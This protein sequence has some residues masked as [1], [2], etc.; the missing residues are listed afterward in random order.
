[1]AKC[2]SCGSIIISGGIKDN[3]LRFCN[4]QCYQNGHVLLLSR[5]VPKNIVDEQAR[6]IHGG[7]CPKC[8]GR[9]PI[10]VHTSYRIISVFV[11]SSWQSIPHI[12]CRAC[13]RK[14]QI[15]DAIFCL[16]LG[17]WGIPWGFFMTPVQIF[18]NIAGIISGPNE[19]KPSDQLD[20]LVR[21]DIAS[22]MKEN[23]QI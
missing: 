21:I 18:K 5:Q 20:K 17:W 12:C 14:K 2:D 3:N 6:Q 16:I 23:K 8:R 22:Q 4:E 15:G 9:G 1:M 7:L 11:Y 13:G 10:D 19:L